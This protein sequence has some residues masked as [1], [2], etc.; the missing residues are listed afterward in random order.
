M[1]STNKPR[2][3]EMSYKSDIEIAQE[4]KMEHIKDIAAKLD[5]SE[6]DIEYYGRYKQKSITI[7]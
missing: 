5:L 4:V 3:T 2:G 6:D 1:D 7:C